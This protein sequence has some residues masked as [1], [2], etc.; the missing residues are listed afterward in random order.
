[1]P[2]TGMTNTVS[3]VYRSDCCGAERTILENHT[4]PPCDA[5]GMSCKGSDTNWM[6]IRKTQTK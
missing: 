6:L 3:G 2:K 5:K 1:M 4:F